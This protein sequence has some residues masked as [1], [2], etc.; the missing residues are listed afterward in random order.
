MPRGL[1]CLAPHLGTRLPMANK[2][3]VK[4]KIKQAAG[5]LTGNQDM[6]NEGKI[7]EL[8]GDVKDKV[9]DI[10][11]KVKEALHKD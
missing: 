7:D 10:V 5:D 4:G 11:D 2:D 1:A 8:A 6:K 9:G 3:Q